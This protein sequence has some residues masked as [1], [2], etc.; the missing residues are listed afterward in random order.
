MDN[1]NILEVMLSKTKRLQKI[2]GDI[3]KYLQ[4]LKNLLVLTVLLEVFPAFGLLILA[5]VAFHLL[6]GG[7]LGQVVS[8]VGRAPIFIQFFLLNTNVFIQSL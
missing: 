3:F 2:E 6:L 1:F 4:I 8:K 5:S 7:L